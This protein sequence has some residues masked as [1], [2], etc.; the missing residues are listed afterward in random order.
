[1]ALMTRLFEPLRQ[2]FRLLLRPL[3]PSK[4]YWIWRQRFIHERLKLVMGISVVM[5]CIMS[6]LN[7][8]L[9]HPAIERSSEEGVVIAQ[10]SSTFLVCLIVGQLL[11]LLLNLI[12]LVHNRSLTLPQIR[13]AFLGNLGA[14]LILPQLQ[15]MVIGETMAD[16][17]GWIIFFMLQAVLIPVQWR[18]HLIS[19]VL[20]MSL[21]SVSFLGLDLA[22]TGVVTTMQ[23]PVYILITVVMTCVFVVADLGIYLYERLL[24]REFELRQQLQLFLHAVSH[25]LRNPVT[26]TLMLLKNLPLQAGKV[27][28]DETV[29]TRMIDSHERQLKLINSL[30]EAHTQEVSG[31]LLDRH[32]LCLL[33]LVSD[34]AKDFQLLLQQVQSRM[35][36]RVAPNLPYVTADALQMRR[37]YD[38]II[39]NALQYNPEGVCITLDASVQGHYLRCTV[40]DD[41]QGIKS[42]T[43]DRPE[44]IANSH[45]WIFDRYSRGFNRRQPLHMGLGLYICQQIVEAHGGQIGVKSELNQG[46]TFWFTLPLDTGQPP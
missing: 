33:T 39:A 4:E 31:I 45:Q 6:I 43:S 40:S 26:G 38:N 11:G 30:L 32:P 13:L 21:I 23:M 29:V 28:L 17:G 12:L 35:V 2:Q 16:L 18:W 19:Q 42:Q 24:L 37:V 3:Q 27:T 36:V 44:A 20:F 41:G 7:L 14:V 15:H 34:I 5:L 9:V 1:M 8:G 10:Y 46:T 25:D 22:F